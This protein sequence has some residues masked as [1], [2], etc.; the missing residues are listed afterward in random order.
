M[1]TIA[2]AF[3]W[4][5]QPAWIEKASELLNYIFIAIFS[6]EAIIKMVALGVK[7]YFSESWTKFDFVILLGS[8][9]GI[10]LSLFS[11]LTIKGAI[12]IIRAFRILRIVRLIKS[13]RS[14]NIMFTTFIVSLPALLNVGGL[15]LLI[16][17]LYSILGM[18]LFGDVM[19]NG[20]FNDSMNF[21]TFSN[22][23]F[24]L[25]AV[26]TSDSWNLITYS[27]VRPYSPTF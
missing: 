12:T 23:F 8:Y 13:A 5:M 27:A 16:L 3:K 11:T 6:C 2:L 25:C 9:A 15:L 24:T 18:E 21:E 26:A 7:S 20:K 17:Y 22:A 10:F 4:Y 14:L 19:R 1:N